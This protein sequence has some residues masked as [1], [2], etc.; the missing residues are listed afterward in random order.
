MTADPQTTADLIAELRREIYHP[1]MQNTGSNEVSRDLLER[2][3]DEI[4]RAANGAYIHTNGETIIGGIRFPSG[5]YHIRRM[6]QKE[7]NNDF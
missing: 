1:I 5:A 2:A 4:V 7:S 6:D 3:L